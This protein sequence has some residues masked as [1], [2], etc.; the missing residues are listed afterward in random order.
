MI[1][2][3]HSAGGHVLLGLVFG[4][5]FS[6][7]PGQTGQEAARSARLGQGGLVHDTAPRRAVSAPLVEQLHRAELELYHL[8]IERHRLQKMLERMQQRAGQTRPVS[9]GQGRPVQ[10]SRRPCT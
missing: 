5:L 8:K 3:R 10:P 4:M 1:A 7:S 2:A 6:W 9:R